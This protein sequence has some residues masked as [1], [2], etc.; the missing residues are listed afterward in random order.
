MNA[1]P[2]GWL[3]CLLGNGG[4][5]TSPPVGLVRGAARAARNV[6]SGIADNGQ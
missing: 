1:W 6:T 4:C 3:G 5:M 2:G